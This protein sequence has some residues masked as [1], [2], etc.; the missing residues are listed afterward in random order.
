MCVNVPSYYISNGR[1]TTT[2]IHFSH[3]QLNWKNQVKCP[4]DVI[5][6]KRS[7]RCHISKSLCTANHR[8]RQL[9]P[10]LNKS[11]QIN[12][13][14]ALT[15]YKS[16]I[17]P[18]LAHAAPDGDAQAKHT[19]TDSI[20]FR[21]KCYERSLKSQQLCQLRLCTKKKLVWKCK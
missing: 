9:Y 21:T 16:V 18:S 5:D 8:L 14:M 12:M 19:S 20:F 11:S 17:R 13:T 4:G 7:Y 15:I 6:S 3:T 10:V 2:S 1:V